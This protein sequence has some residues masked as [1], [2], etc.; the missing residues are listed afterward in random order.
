MHRRMLS[1]TDVMVA[2]ESHVAA[3]LHQFHRAD[4]AEDFRRELENPHLH[5]ML[6]RIA[7]GTVVVLFDGNEGFVSHGADQHGDGHP[8]YRFSWAGSIS[9]DHDPA[10]DAFAGAL[11]ACAARATVKR[12]Q[13]MVPLAL[14]VA[15]SPEWAA[16]KR[17]G[18]RP[19]RN[20]ST[21][22]A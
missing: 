20:R 17:S 4:A 14:K 6:R 10:T 7:F 2:H 12:F 9:G 19:Q 11:A 21:A 22:N 15:A 3:L 5:Q 16:M 18:D 8:F 13:Q 1:L